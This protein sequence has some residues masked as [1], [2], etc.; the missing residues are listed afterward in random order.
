ME[1]RGRS[2]LAGRPAGQREGP[3]G[4]CAHSSRAITPICLAKFVGQKAAAAAVIVN[5]LVGRSFGFF[6]RPRN[7]LYRRLAFSLPLDSSP[8]SAVGK[9]VLVAAAAALADHRDRTLRRRRRHYALVIAGR[10]TQPPHQ[11]PAAMLARDGQ[12][13]KMG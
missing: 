13:P 12:M 2:R 5:E 9:I 1:A 4:Q 11:I 8:S 3:S 7:P 10:R 6:G